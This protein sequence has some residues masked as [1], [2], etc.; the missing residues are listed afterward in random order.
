MPWPKVLTASKI[1]VS[2]S[3]PW[4]L[5]WGLVLAACFSVPCLLWGLVLAACIRLEMSRSVTSWIGRDRPSTGAKP[6][7]TSPVWMMSSVTEMI[8]SAF[9]SKF[10]SPVNTI[11]SP[12]VNPDRLFRAFTGSA[13]VTNTPSAAS[14][15]RNSMTTITAVTANASRKGEYLRS[16]PIRIRPLL[17]KGDYTGNMGRAR[18]SMILDHRAQD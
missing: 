10:T 16:T 8:P 3:V 17:E 13:A 4:S 7:S 5:L 9:P 11:S 15:R 2:F 18:N 1:T 6:R 12:V 14:G